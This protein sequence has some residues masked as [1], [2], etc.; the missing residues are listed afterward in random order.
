MLIDSYCGMIVS[1]ASPATRR[2]LSPLLSLVLSLCSER[3]PLGPGYGVI[4]G[5]EE[6][7]ECI[8]GMSGILS[9][10][11]SLA[12]YETFFSAQ[13]LVLVQSLQRVGNLAN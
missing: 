3:K 12:K 11:H 13:L 5:H 2:F 9:L 7:L 6:T 1:F 10:M 8:K 4:I